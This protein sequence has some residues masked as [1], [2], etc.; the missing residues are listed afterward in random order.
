MKNIESIFESMG[1]P[2]Q[3]GCDNEFDTTE[4]RFF[5]V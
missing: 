1:K 3:I 2:E 4:F 5:K